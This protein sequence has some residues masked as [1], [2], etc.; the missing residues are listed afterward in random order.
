MAKLRLDRRTILNGAG[1]LGATAALARVL[2]D[3]AAAAGDA[4]ATSAKAPQQPAPAADAGAAFDGDAVRKMAERLAQREFQRP[5]LELPEP[6]NNLS[7]DQY[8]DIRFKPDQAIWR[9]DKV[10]YELQ[11]LAAGFLY[12]V[13]VEISVVEN[14]KARLLKADDHLFTIGPLINKPQP[15]APF[16]FSGFRIHAPINRSDY[17]DELA[18]FQGA[19]YFRAVARGQVYGM[20]ARGLAINTARTGGEEFPF[21]RAFWIE[22]PKPGAHE[23]VVH[24]LLDSPST[25]GAYRFVI[26]PG[27]STIID[28]DLVL[29]P[30]KV[31]S[32]VGIG[33]L[34]SMFLYGSASRRIHGDFRPAVHDSEGLAII[35]GSGERI[36]RPL[37]NPRKLQASAFVDKD[38]KGFGLSQRNRAFA[39]F[40]DLE[41][42]YEK[43]PTV[44]VE[45]KGAWGQGFVE[46]I[47]I[48]AEEE[49]HDNVVAYWKPEKGLE[50]GAAHAFSYRM[51]WTDAVPVSPPAARVRQTFV[52][53]GKKPG[54]LLFVIDFDGAAFK[55]VRELPVAHVNV[56]A[57]AVA[58]IVA[59]QNA[60]VSGL[61]VSFEVAPGGADLIELRLALKAA[62]QQI[63]ETWLYRWTRT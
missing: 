43:R 41:A 49:I 51:Y 25:T 6:Y 1:A 60:E 39:G 32:H 33:C 59:Q 31:L 56:S 16:G 2:H 10:D 11:L 15:G 22:R 7:Y 34:T 13:P 45:P 19:S 4:P 48:P 53:S 9:G 14:G 61:R 18:V 21:F 38:P 23:I 55:E 24:A 20:S 35:N 8:R 44:W 62:E 29:F 3:S 47:E 52:G 37:T 30:R 57:G 42:R 50:P 40:E 58:N 63:S 27:Q 17:Y 36:W 46:L 12:D 26:Q 28:V 5:K 54:T